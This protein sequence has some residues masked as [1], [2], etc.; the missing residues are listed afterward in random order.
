MESFAHPASLADTYDP[1]RNEQSRESSLAGAM[2]MA[3]A[4]ASMAD[5]QNQQLGL[6]TLYKNLAPQK[7]EA[8]KLQKSKYIDPSTGAV[9]WGDFL[10]SPEGNEWAQRYPQVASVIFEK[11][12]VLSGGAKTP[13]GTKFSEFIDQM[14]PESA[15]GNPTQLIRTFGPEYKSW[16]VDQKIATGSV[17]ALT[18]VLHD[19]TATPEQKKT[20][21]ATL[22][23]QTKQA[24]AKGAAM[25]VG[26]F[27]T[28]DQ[29]SPAQHK[30]IDGLI[31][32]AYQNKVSPGVFE[33][34]AKTF[35]ANMEAA[36]QS[37]AR[38]LHPDWDQTKWEQNYSYFK[39]PT[40]QRYM[41]N[42][43]NVM[44]PGGSLAKSIELA[45]KVDNPKARVWGALERQFGKQTS[46]KM[47]EQFNSAVDLSSDELSQIFGSRGGGERYLELA[48]GML[49]K[50]VSAETFI[51][52]AKQMLELVKNRAEEQGAGS[53]FSKEITDSYAQLESKIGKIGEGASP[54]AGGISVDDFNKMK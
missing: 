50:D 18:Q 44:G 8:G 19:P 15:G 28:W 9:R 3:Q 54:A 4:K 1:I 48:K 41:R 36:V 20:A 12:G 45:S 34:S 25:S 17:G 24:G 53:S 16:V 52:N 35:G 30:Q 29:L 2:N 38:E 33:R 11:S 43:K 46:N 31:E 40:T 51:S 13:L 21:E 23:E 39:S 47:R 49:D 42:I 5:S 37:R 27:L 10:N 26:K 22:R 7:D 14:H 32:Q 6:A